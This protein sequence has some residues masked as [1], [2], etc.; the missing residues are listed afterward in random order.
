[1]AN[2]IAV[3]SLFFGGGARGQTFVWGGGGGVPRGR[4]RN[5]FFPITFIVHNQKS[6]EG[7]NAH[8]INGGGGGH[9]PIVTPLPHSTFITDY[10]VHINIYD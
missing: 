10:S 2:H 6:N 1:M 5:D 4:H 9:A 8:G 7:D 3:V